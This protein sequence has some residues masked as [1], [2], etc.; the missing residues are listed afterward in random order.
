MANFNVIKKN[1]QHQIIVCDD[2][3]HTL[4]VPQLEEHYHSVHGAI[5]ESMHVFI[6]MGLLSLASTSI[7]ILEVGFCTGLN[8]LLTLVSAPEKKV[9]YH[10]V[11][12]YP[13]DLELA[14]QLNYGSHLPGYS[15]LYH[16][17]N[18]SPWEE[19]VSIA[20]NFMLHKSKAD[21]RAVELVNTYDLVYFDAFAPSKQPDLWEN[22]VFAAIFKQMN[23]N[24]ILVTYCAKGSVRRMLKEVGFFVE[25]LPGPPGKREM[26]RAI[27]LI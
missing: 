13:L 24:G 26:L 1:W 22:D 5:N 3:S 2:G 10:A 16:Q 11:E 9:H 15:D 14:D 8:A 25:R 7:S 20:S 18:H 17:L 4:Y 6:Q 21:F 27:R 19:D 23:L 12:K